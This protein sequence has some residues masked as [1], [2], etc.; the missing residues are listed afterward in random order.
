MCLTKITNNNTLDLL[1]KNYNYATVPAEKILA[2][3]VFVVGST[4]ILFYGVK[5]ISKYLPFFLMF[6]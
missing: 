1:K 5:S 6:L 2:E 4:T 3:S